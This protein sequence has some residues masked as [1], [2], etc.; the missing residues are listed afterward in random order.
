MFTLFILALASP[1]Q[2]T[3]LRSMPFPQERP[4]RLRQSATMRRL[5]A[6]TRVMPHQL[7]QP[8]FVVPGKGVVRPIP[9]MPGISQYS[10][11]GLVREAQTL[12]ESGIQAVLLFGVPE[13]KDPAGKGA[14]ADEGLVQQACRALGERVPGLLLITDVCL[15]AYTDHGHCGIVRGSNIDND[16]SL[17]LLTKT[18]VSHVRAGAHIVAPSDMMDGRVAAIRRGLDGGGFSDT[19][20]LSYAVKYASAFYGPFRDAQD[21]APTH[22]DRTTYQMDPPNVREALREVRLDVA[23][24]ADMVMVKPAM[25]YLDVIRAV[26]ETV[27]IPVAAYQVSGEYAMLKASAERGWLDERRAVLE[28]LTAIRRAGADIIVTYYAKSAAAWL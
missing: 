9:S 28:S 7:I 5:L 21:S 25:P 24:G 4:R 26:R 20:I 13:G 17:E 8:L 15:C 11:D 3:Y 12:V 22:G 6:E 1:Q 14:Y 16:A 19:P 10:P 27:D 18:A 2:Q 23:E